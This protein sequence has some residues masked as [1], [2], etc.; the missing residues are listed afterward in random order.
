GERRRRV[1]EE[2]RRERQVEERRWRWQRQQRPRSRPVKSS[3]KR[4]GRSGP[5]TGDT[6]RGYPPQPARASGAAEWVRRPLFFAG[7]GG[8]ERAEGG[9]QAAGIVHEPD[10]DPLGIEPHLGGKAVAPLRVEL[11]G[12]DGELLVFE[13]VDGHVG[14]GGRHPESR[15]NLVDRFVVAG[16]HPEPVCSRAEPAPVPRGLWETPLLPPV[17]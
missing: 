12:E 6:A 10:V 4:S 1:E 7:N 16:H 2:R 14:P 13:A 15:R 3:G 9:E 17:G 8:G 5:G 11:P